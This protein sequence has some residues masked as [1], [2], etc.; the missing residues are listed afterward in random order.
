MVVYADEVET[1]PAT[2]E[3]IETTEED[4]ETFKQEVSEW[5]SKWFD[6]QQVKQIIQW[7]VDS[8]VLIALFGVVL[9]YKK[10]KNTSIEELF[11]KVKTELK[12]YLEENFKKM[13]GEEIQKIVKSIETL[14]QSTE[15]IMKVLV[16][17]QDSTAKGKVALIEYLGTKTNNVEVKE[18][19]NQVNEVIEKQEQV[20]QEIID[21]VK[22]PYKEIF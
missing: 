21:K 11:V 8:G 14:E 12:D 1:T 6:E 16:L 22:D 19:A 18:L 20:K 9:K 10:Y 5:L 17:A 13:S 15:T 3:T 4:I 7:L 2:T